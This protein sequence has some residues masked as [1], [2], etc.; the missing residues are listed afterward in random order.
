M[1]RVAV[2]GPG[3]V[4]ST[5]AAQ[6]ALAGRHDLVVCARRPFGRLVVESPQAPADVAVDVVTEPGQ[7]AGRAPVDWVLLAVKA[8]QTSGA[9]PWLEALCGP[10]TRVVVIQNGVEQVERAAAV[11]G[12][13]TVVPAVVYCA[14][15]LLAPGRVEH[16]YDVRLLVPAGP[17]ADALAELFAGTVASV[18]PQEHWATAAWVKL[19]LNTVLNGLTGITA[20][21]MGVLRRPGMD[22]A[23]RGLLEEVAAVAVA[24]GAQLPPD[25]VERTAAALT[26]QPEDGITSMLQD[27]RAGRPTEHD[28]LHGA[29]LRAGARLGVPTPRHQ[30]LWALLEATAPAGAATR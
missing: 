7:L 20:Q 17:D 21:P 9:R 24:A 4:G 12:P 26:R 8:H 15:E 30:Q 27:R 13:A 5:F 1:S 19:S 3:G 16:R 28:A 25:Y 14:A 18:E 10:G 2:V 11:S 29:V 6:L 23:A 22:E